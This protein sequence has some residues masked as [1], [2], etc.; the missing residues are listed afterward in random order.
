MFGVLLADVVCWL[1]EVKVVFF[2][3]K[4]RHSDIILLLLERKELSPHNKYCLFFK[5]FNFIVVRFQA[6]EMF[7][8]IVFN[9]ALCFFIMALH[10]KRGVKTKGESSY[11]FLLIISTSFKHKNGKQQEHHFY[12]SSNGFPRFQSELK[13]QREWVIG[14][15]PWTRQSVWLIFY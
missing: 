4:I 10:L 1:D 13:A 5:T 9:V 8:F 6:P 7:N 14:M 3:A 12:C 11:I 15:F 2:F